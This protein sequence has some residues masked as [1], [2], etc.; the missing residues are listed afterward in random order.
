MNDDHVYFIREN[1]I[2]IT[3]TFSLCLYKLISK[4]YTT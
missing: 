3:I 2:S 4:K 1:V